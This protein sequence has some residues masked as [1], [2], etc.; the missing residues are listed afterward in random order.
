[1]NRNYFYSEELYHIFQLCEQAPFGKG[2]ETVVDTSVRNAWQID[3]KNVTV[4]SKFLALIKNQ[5]T[6]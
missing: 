5:V 4:E 1:M 2:P 3:C 6:Y